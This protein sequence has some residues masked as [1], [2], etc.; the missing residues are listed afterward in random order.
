M[1]LVETYQYIFINRVFRTFDVATKKVISRNCKAI[2]PFPP[3]HPLHD[4]KVRLYHD[5]TLQTYFRR[6]QFSPDGLLIAV[7][8]GK[9]EPEQGK[10]DFKPMNAVY[11]YTRY[12]LKV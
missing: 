3:E 5:D 4:T 2:L 7:P 1:N 10:V 9:I 8:S 12:S 11:I 6:L